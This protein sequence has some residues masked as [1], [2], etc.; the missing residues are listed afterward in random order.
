[1]SKKISLAA[2]STVL[3]DLDGTV[4]YGNR[5]IPGANEAITL[6]RDLGKKIYFT[7]NNSFFSKKQVHQRLIDIGVQCKLEEVLTSGYMAAQ[8]CS[9]HD[10]D[11]VFVFGSENLINEFL[12]HGVLINQTDQAKNLV[13]GYNPNFNYE[14]L[15]KAVRVA[16]NSKNIIACNRERVYPGK[17]AELYPGCGAM[18]APVEWCSGKVCDIIIGKPNSAFVEIISRLDKIPASNI[19]MIG[20][21]YESDILMANRAGCPSV[22][23]SNECHEDTFVIDSIVNISKV[24]KDSL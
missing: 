1:M 21:T 2:I 9:L 20:D 8:Y 15:T 6:F 23:I 12:D 10:I 24:F 22:L 13:I 5:I 19:L 4:Y 17:D 3:F 18:T 14:E 16:I 7:T 11:D